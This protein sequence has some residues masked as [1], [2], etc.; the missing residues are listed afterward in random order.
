MGVPQHDHVEARHGAARDE[1]GVCVR[2]DVGV[3]VPRRAVAEED[4]FSARVD[5]ERMR[6]AA[7]RIELAGRERIER[8]ADTAAVFALD[9]REHPTV[10]TRRSEHVFVVAAHDSMRPRREKVKHALH[11]EVVTDEV[12]GN[13]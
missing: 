1:F 2:I 13:E 9:G 7:Q 6:E 11:V 5:L 10:G 4:P 12:S 3:V 8:N